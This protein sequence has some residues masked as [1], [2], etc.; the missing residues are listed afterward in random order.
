MRPKL[1][2]IHSHLNFPEF[3]KDREEM[4]AKMKEKEIFSIII[5]TDECTS[6]GAIELAE[7][8]VADENLFASVG[9][10]PTSHMEDEFLHGDLSSMW[11]EFAKHPK[12]VAI[13]E[14]GID[15]FRKDK[16]DL[17][18][19]A[20]IF[21]EHIELAIEVGKPLM[22]HCRNAHDE[23]LE[24]LGHYHSIHGD[25]LRGNIHF[26]SGDMGIA[27]KYFNLGFSISFAGVI[28]FS[29]DY[30][31]VIRNAPLDKI[32]IETDSPFVAPVPHRGKRNEPLYV[33]EIAKKIAEIRGIS[34]EEVAKVTTDNALRLFCGE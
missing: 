6:R 9:V 7:S 26:F 5:G 31:E 22:I 33:T 27:Q 32:M 15:L 13:G 23:V 11:R 29:R 25:K 28:T 18:R 21:K 12:V 19:Q 17:K 8:A 14:C 10:H 1:F 30:D 4:I 16:S 34:Y 24:I 3:D 2:D 20:D